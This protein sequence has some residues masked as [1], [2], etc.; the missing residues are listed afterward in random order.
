MKKVCAAVVVLVALV[1]GAQA[2]TRFGFGTITD[3]N[4]DAQGS[5]R[6]GP[7]FTVTYE[8]Y[9]LQ[10][11]SFLKRSVHPVGEKTRHGRAVYFLDGKPSTPA[12]ALKVGRAV[13]MSDNEMIY[14]V[15][16][17][18][19]PTVPGE[20]GT[21]ENGLCDAELKGAFRTALAKR[22]R[23]K[24]LGAFKEVQW[25]VNLLADCRDGKV[26]AA[27]VRIGP[28]DCLL[29]SGA[30]QM[31]DGRLSGTIECTVALPADYRYATKDGKPVQVALSFDA[32]ADAGGVLT[33]SVRGTS[34]DAAVEGTVEGTILPRAPER[35]ASRAWLCVSDFGLGHFGYVVAPV[36]NGAMKDGYVL[37]NK[38][39]KVGN[40][41]PVDVA[42]RDGRIQG[43]LEIAAKRHSTSVSKTMALDGVVLGNRVLFGSWTDTDGAKRS[44]WGGIVAADGPQIEAATAEQLEQVKAMQQESK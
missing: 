23:D 4:L 37:Y 20:T 9:S 17:Q 1:S 16:S 31:R 11:S 39:P 32:G 14:H 28:V 41:A 40:A 5:G 34:G 30:V 8:F 38:G 18:P 15:S 25:S 33:G 2:N 35:D 19:G 36:V 27:V 24:S 3:V 21:L 10:E 26:A 6:K 43:S 7:S 42:V 44:F 22:N 12:E 13:C 29:D